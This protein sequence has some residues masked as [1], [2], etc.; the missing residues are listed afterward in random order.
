MAQWGTVVG[1][2]IKVRKFVADDRVWAVKMV[3]HE[4]GSTP[5]YEKEWAAILWTVLN[6]WI[7]RYGQDKE[8][9]GGYIQRF[10]QPVNPNEIG[11]VREYDYRA[12]EFQGDPEECAGAAGT[13]MCALARA[14]ARWNR[15]EN[16][17][18]RPLAWYEQN[19]P[20]IVATVQKF[21]A[22]GLPNRE[23]P[24]WTDFAAQYAGHGTEDTSVSTEGTFANSFYRET[25][26]GD[27]T[28]DT[29]KIVAPASPR[30]AGLGLLA[31][32]LLTAGAVIGMVW[33]R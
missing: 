6:R 25:W 16:N 23:F 7:G 17:R 33:R 8:T 18:K 9:F 21:M 31:A 14:R 12:Q 30:K 26:A 19:V 10:S 27:W 32:L 2:G 13:E 29:V 3:T 1:P 20:A 11:R 15:I 28:G 5:E 22:G 4:T 24:G